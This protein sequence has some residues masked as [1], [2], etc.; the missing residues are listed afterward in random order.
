MSVTREAPKTGRQDQDDGGNSA[1]T[2]DATPYRYSVS[3]E[4]RE[5]GGDSATATDAAPDRYSVSTEVPLSARSLAI[6]F[7]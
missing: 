6:P 1:T 2:S 5:D 3:T 4:V 7:L